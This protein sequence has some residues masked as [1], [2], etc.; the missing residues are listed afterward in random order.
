MNFPEIEERIPT[1]FSIQKIRFDIKQTNNRADGYR[2]KVGY[3]EYFLYNA[4]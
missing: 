4:L 2:S 3:R 1:N